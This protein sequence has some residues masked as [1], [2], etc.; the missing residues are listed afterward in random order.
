MKCVCVC[1][2]LC[3]CMTSCPPFVWNFWTLKYYNNHNAKYT[4]SFHRILVSWVLIFHEF[5]PPIFKSVSS[6]LLAH[7]WKVSVLGN[8][9][10]PT[11][12][13]PSKKKSIFECGNF[14]RPSLC[15]FYSLTLLLREKVNELW[16]LIKVH[17]KWDLFPTS[18]EPPFPPPQSGPGVLDIGT[19]WESGR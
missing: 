11:P 4:W 8:L 18:P 7:N 14:W 12:S 6:G 19:Q 9:L 1:V 17:L 16:L 3:V 2:W 15:T 10:P 13:P 5:L